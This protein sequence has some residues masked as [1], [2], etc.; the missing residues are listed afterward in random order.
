MPA[1]YESTSQEER[2]MFSAPSGLPCEAC[3]GCGLCNISDSRVDF[4]GNLNDLSAV[5]E[6]QQAKIQTLFKMAGFEQKIKNWDES[7]G[8]EGKFSFE[9]FGRTFQG[10]LSKLGDITLTVEITQ[11]HAIT[12]PAVHPISREPQH[13]MPKHE[14][15][16]QEKKPDIQANSAETQQKIPIDSTPKGVITESKIVSE[17]LPEYI[18]HSSDTYQ[19]HQ[20]IP[21][22]ME[23]PETNQITYIVVEP[24][25]V[26]PTQE[27]SFIWLTDTEDSTWEVRS[28]GE[29]IID[30]DDNSFDIVFPKKTENSTNQ[31]TA[32]KKNSD[33]QML[34]KTIEQDTQIIPIQENPMK[35]EPEQPHAEFAK[36][37][38][39]HTEARQALFLFISSL[40][41]SEKKDDP[42]L[43]QPG[44]R[45]EERDTLQ[46]VGETE[47][48]RDSK[49]SS[50]ETNNKIIT[51]EL[52][53]ESESV[54]RQYLIGAE[55]KII[56]L[57]GMVQI[58][59]LQK[60]YDHTHTEQY[61]LQ[62]EN[63]QWILT[64]VITRNEP[65]KI[66]AQAQAINILK[67]R[68]HEYL[69]PII[70]NIDGQYLQADE[71]KLYDDLQVQ[72]DDFMDIYILWL[73]V[74]FL[75]VLLAMFDNSS[76][77]NN[78]K[79][80]NTPTY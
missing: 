35:S 74:N 2:G 44:Q 11:R 57:S 47:V 4:M 12:E 39:T 10:T 15:E 62:E 18:E 21:L 25:T 34:P 55:A 28:D 17:D 36:L 16:I 26:L 49:I 22:H 78:F 60:E 1:E 67:E 70:L 5:P 59:K 54:V 71:E 80:I 40:A 41:D 13:E 14:Y 52:P 38:Q 7:V 19:I 64:L 23:Q 27:E 24:K 20:T 72:T 6:D 56:T 66:V 51:I 75:F 37:V 30:S 32:N 65:I 58:E 8:N 31:D 9:R 48:K 33:V 50:T 61:V 68:L 53:N 79:Y 29:V 3:S 73:C 63:Q 69:E 45:D 76:I 42:I 46:T 43:D 77:S